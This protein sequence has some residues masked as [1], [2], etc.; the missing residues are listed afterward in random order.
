MES[1]QD[2][3]RELTAMLE[4]WKKDREVGC[5]AWA[6]GRVNLIGDHTDY[7]E[8][9]VLPMTIGET[10]HVLARPAA[11]RLNRVESEVF[12]AVVE[13]AVGEMPEEAS[14]S[15]ATYVGG[16][17]REL[18]LREG[19]NMALEMRVGGRVPIG[20]G[21]SS[22]AAL[23]MAVAMAVIRLTDMDL[24]AVSAARMGQYVEHTYVGVKCGIMDQMV[25]ANGTPRHA[26]LLDCR[27]LEFRHVP[28]GEAVFVALDSGVCR[29]LAAT[30]YNERRAE[31]M[32]VLA[33]CS[34]LDPSIRALRDVGPE[35]LERFAVGLRGTLAA[36][37]RHVV[38][39]NTRVHRA[40]SA[41]EAGDLLEFGLY[42]YQSH[43]SLRD[44]Y[45]VSCPELDCLVETAR[46]APGV[47]GARMTGG[48]FGGCTV[49]A[50]EAGRV[51]EFTA[52]VQ[53]GYAREFSRLAV[54]YLIKDNQR[55]RALAF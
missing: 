19:L 53:S 50:V 23:E 3:T 52:H 54:P 39:E 35:R 36:R 30:K 2:S 46:H 40:A 24:D 34:R 4:A 16:M 17:L 32:E 55:A 6:P 51:Q 20:A 15:W 13:F 22:S 21:L 8:G 18:H 27:S 49:N 44:L 43:E 5:A 12:E 1:E 48:G 11:G 14:L 7:S 9:F 37:L 29:E 25:C 31:C 38:A 47:L 45:E 33:H 10:V 28:V 26:L 41:L 42:M